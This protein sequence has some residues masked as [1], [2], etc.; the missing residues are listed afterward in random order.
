MSILKISKSWKRT[1]LIY[2]KDKYFFYESEYETNRDYRAK[3]TWQMCL[4][5][6][7]TYK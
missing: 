7:L 2:L 4:L 5:I 1:G 3:Q 6:E